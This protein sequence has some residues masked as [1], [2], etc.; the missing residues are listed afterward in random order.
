MPDRSV[1]DATC[2]IDG[3]YA[4]PPARVCKA[5]EDPVQKRRWFVEGEGWEVERFETDFRV[6]G[7][8]R[9]SFR[10]QGGPL[11]TNDTLFQDIVPGERI[12]I[13]YTMTVG[14]NRI[15]VSQATMQFEPAGG[16][17]RLVFTEPDAFLAAYAAHRH[18][19]PPLPDRPQTR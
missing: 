17:P 4:G 11:I 8:E 12:V 14:G 2:T 3:L 6:G 13:A 19:E 10:F 5:F 7:F 16:G 18:R 15:S 9:G 1:T